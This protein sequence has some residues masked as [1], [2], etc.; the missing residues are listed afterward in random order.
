MG[1]LAIFL[2][3]VASIILGALSNWLYDLLRHRKVFPKRPSI[4]RAVIICV[5]SIPFLVLVALPNLFNDKV[6]DNDPN[7]SISI[8]GDV[9]DSTIIQSDE[10]DAQLS[11]GPTPSPTPGPTPTAN[12]YSVDIAALTGF[13]PDEIL[14]IAYENLD[15]YGA[16]EIIVRIQPEETIETK[17]RIFSYLSPKKQWLEVLDLNQAALDHQV[18]SSIEYL[19]FD[20]L[21]LKQDNTRQI[22]VH[23][24]RGTGAFVYFE[25]YEYKGLTFAERLYALPAIM[26]FSIVRIV[27]EQ[28][29]IS[30]PQAY[31]H[32]NWNGQE[33]ELEEMKTAVPPVGTH[34]VSYWIENGQVQ[35]S[36][37]QIRLHI[38][39]YISFVS[40]S[41]HG[42]EN[43]CV[44]GVKIDTEYFDFT[45][46]PDL[47][48][49]KKTGS[50]TVSLDCVWSGGGRA[51]VK[52]DVIE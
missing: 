12:A 31:Y 22:V 39:E 32:V 15:G 46:M 33:I 41:N 11:T 44:R 13:A 45:E 47:I 1:Q 35:L 27:N 48:V 21:N 14:E 9:I 34:V 17:I 52:V 2:S 28:M 6:Q 8:G 37:N 38:G 26:S 20:I 19:E 24:S 42:M 29:Y 49:A 7:K 50:K 36:T 5:A 25:I 40:D 43:R 3:I 10:V 30:S 51:E 23:Q 16:D 4:K 18:D